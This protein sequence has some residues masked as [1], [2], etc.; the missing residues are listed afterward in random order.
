MSSAGVDPKVAVRR[1]RT[2]VAYLVALVVGWATYVTMSSQWDV[3]LYQWRVFVT[4]VFGAFVAGSTPQGG[5]SVAFP[6]FTKVFES[7]A[8]L[9]RSFSLCIQVVGMGSAAVS[10]LIARRSVSRRAV[11]VGSLSGVVG[12]VFGLFV[13]GDPSTVWWSAIIPE[14]YVKVLFT[15]VLAAMAYIVYLALDETDCGLW[16]IPVWNGNVWVGLIVF[17]FIGGV[18][19]SLIGS[20]ADAVVF[21]FI[22][23]VAG[24]HPRIGIPTSVII[25]AV[26]SVVGMVILG[27]VHGQLSTVVIDDML[28]AVGGTPVAPV[29]AS[30]FD[31]WGMW[32]AGAPAAAV[33]GPLGAAF[34][35]RLGEKHLIRFIITISTLEVVTTAVFLEQLRTD[36]RLLAIALIGLPVVLGAVWLLHR[37][38]DWLLGTAAPSVVAA[39]A[40]ERARNRAGRS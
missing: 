35:H 40:R 36:P 39:D 22:V 24:L 37:N 21:L 34:V 3:V 15:L 13:L 27:I 17:G 38:R 8:A 2:I 10:I 19:S 5:G 23:I 18:T 29:P 1:S 4:M 30:Q 16:Y 7:P 31:L 26:V 6:V 14:A 20:G 9:A 28:V 32:L 11:T 33:L 12:L 25:M